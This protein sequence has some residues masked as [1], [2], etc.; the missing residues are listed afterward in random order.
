MTIVK[1][2]LRITRGREET[3]F[4]RMATLVRWNRNTI[5]AFISSHIIDYPTPVNLNYMWSFGST[6]GLCLVIQIIT[7]IF[8]A[9]HYTPHVDLAF[10]SVEHIM[11]D[12]NNGWIIRYLHANGA[13][14]F[15]IVIYCH[16][17]RGLYYGS[18]MYPRG[19]LWGSGVLIFLLM[20]A[21][22]FMGY[23]LPWGQMSFWGATVITNLFS[24]IPLVGSSIVEWLWGGFSVDNATLNRFF[25][26]HYLMP[27]LIAGLTLIHLSLLHKEGSNNP[28]GVNSAIDTIAFYPYF[29]VKDLFSFLILVCIFS[30]FLFF[31]PNALGHADN[32]I[33]ANPLVTPPHIVPEWYFLPFYAI[34]RS[35]PDKL[36]G[37]VAMISAILVLF[38][39]PIINTSETRSSKFRPVFKVMYWFLVSDFVILGWIGQ[40][41][42]ESPFIEIGMFATMFYFLFMIVLVPLIGIME[43]VMVEATGLDLDVRGRW[44]PYTRKEYFSISHTIENV[45]P[46]YL[47]HGFPVNDYNTVYLT[48]PFFKPTPWQLDPKIAMCLPMGE[49]PLHANY[50]LCRDWYWGLNEEDKL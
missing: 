16:I 4:P 14:M 45:G 17:F 3:L 22:A 7:G 28:L 1:N 48:K 21:T 33:P 2:I 25:S 9:M 8:L 47:L 15:F 6:A 19:Q 37:V 44:Y 34:L 31:Y 39:L 43:K 26:L 29:Y 42:V 24:A 49:S 30:L 38:L 35:I 23:V 32:Y 41:P 46:H 50:N 13:S 11:R 18:Y 5:L 36:G 12:V 10:S 20:M 27:F 40:K